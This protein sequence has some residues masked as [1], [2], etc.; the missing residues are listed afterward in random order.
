MAG[1]EVEHERAYG[2]VDQE[3][4]APRRGS[5]EVAPEERAGRRG[6]AAEPGPGTDG[7]TAVL[8]DERGLQDGQA[9]RGE[10]GGADPLENPG[11]D[12]NGGARREGAGGRGEG[13]PGHPD[14]EDAAPSV[15]V[16]EG[17]AEQDERGH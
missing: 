4:P 16:A 14:G 11:G 2:Y 7:P 5:D 13:E 15:P 10:Q 17:P 12:E 9:P 1:R 8:A 3:D 6:H